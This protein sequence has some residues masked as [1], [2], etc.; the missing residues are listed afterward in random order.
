MFRKT[1]FKVVMI[2]A[3]AIFLAVID[4]PVLESNN[5]GFYGWMRSHNINLGL[6][7]QGGTQLRY[8]IDLSEI[9]EQDQAG[10]VDG[11]LTV[12]KRRVNGLGVAEPV[13]QSAQFGGQN[14]VLV[15]LPGIHDIDEAIRVVGKTVQLDFREQKESFTEAELKDI[16]AYNVTQKTKAQEVLD[17]ALAGDDW[18]KL[19]ELYSEGKYVESGGESGLQEKS[20]FREDI[21]DA[22]WNLTPGTIYGKVQEI[23]EGFNILKLIDKKSEEVEVDIPEE[24]QASHL[25][26]SY[27]GSNVNYA[28]DITRSQQEAEELA[29]ELKT[30]AQSEDF[31]S[32]VKEYSDDASNKDEGGELG[33]FGRDEMVPQ[34][35]KAAFEANPG[36]IVGPIETEFGY[37]LI[38]VEAKRGGDSKTETIEKANIGKIFLK[39]KSLSPEGGWQTTAL[40]GEHFKNAQA[41]VDQ[42]SYEFIVK[43]QFNEAGVEL[44]K[45][46]T[47]KNLNKPLAIFLDDEPIIDAGEDANGEPVA[48]APTV[49]SVITDGEA[50]ISGALD[51]KEA[52]ELA[53]NLNTGAIPAPVQL[54]GQ[55]NIGASLGEGSLK[56]SV[57]AGLIGFLVVVLFMLVYY[58]LPGLMASVALVIYSIFVMA[59]FKFLPG[60]TLTLAGI[61][62][63][64]LS[65]GMAVDANVLIFERLKEELKLG[66]TLRSAV[67][68]GFQRAW[69]SIRD[70]NVSSLITCAVLFVFGTGI[71]KGFA[72]TLAIGILISMFSAIVVTRNFLRVFIEH[73][74]A[75][76]EVLWGVNIKKVDVEK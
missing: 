39:K 2:M 76:N 56:E 6:D 37:H 21:V 67:E 24:V 65:I 60:Y 19:A 32:L 30:R 1:W 72:L 66:K 38:K 4:L 25:L 53:S 12:I 64:I 36:E 63:F 20:Y 52:H 27:K 40:T 33:Y 16:K 75:K 8:R 47:E 5:G 31:A 26:V 54:V 22:V 62:G 46:V 28:E 35:E 9:D 43:I 45:Q 68:S 55:Y 29:N 41:S 74:W 18:G 3:A 14:Y 48:Y 58:R 44:F 17:K 42:Q 15:E 73:K 51:Q 70:S 7:L 71:I 49:R 59:T 13:V 69:S 11:V 61:A 57:N 50:I 34:F 10:I 23:D